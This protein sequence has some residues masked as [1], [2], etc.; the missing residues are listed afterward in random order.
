[1][2]II[3]HSKFLVQPVGFF[4]L[5]LCVG[6]VSGR[7]FAAQSSPAKQGPTS[8]PRTTLSKSRSRSNPTRVFSLAASGSN[9]LT[10]RWE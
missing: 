3:F 10:V 8:Q 5:L 9:D 7:A 2:T 1:M 6:L 4:F